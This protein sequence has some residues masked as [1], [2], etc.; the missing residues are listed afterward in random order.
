MTV[1]DCQYRGQVRL[2]NLLL[3]DLPE[4]VRNVLRQCLTQ[5]RGQVRLLNLLLQDLPENVRNILRQCLPVNTED[6]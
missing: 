6:R 3:Q 1:F 5:Y 4:D 2:L